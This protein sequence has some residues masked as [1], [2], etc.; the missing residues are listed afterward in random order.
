M[1]DTVFRGPTVSAGSLMDGRVEPFDG[2]VINYQGEVIPDVRFSPLPKNAMQPGQAESFLSSPYIVLVDNLLQSSANT[3]LIAASAAATSGVAVTLNATALGPG[4]GFA[5]TPSFCPGIPIIPFG[6]QSAT[7]VA[8]IDFGFTTG[9]TVA[10]SSTV[11]VV[12][13][14]LVQTGQWLMLGGT[15]ASNKSGTFAQIQTIAN[16]TT[17]TVLP[18]PVAALTNAPIGSVNLYGA[19]LL[20]PATQFGPSTPT[21]TGVNPYVA[22]GMASIF[23]P[24]EAVTR[25]IRFASTTGVLGT[26]QFLI[27]GY[28]VFGQ[29][30]TELVTAL[31][32][33]PAFSKKAFKYVQTI[34]PQQTQAGPFTISIGDTVGFHV[35]S[36][37]WEY[38]DTF[39]NG[40][41]ASNNAGWT[42]AFTGPATATTGD[43]RGTIQLSTTG[44]LGT[45]VGGAAT[46][47]STT[48][49]T[50]MMSVPLNNLVNATPINAVPMF[51]QTQA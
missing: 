39:W 26:A 28:D 10:A 38:T 37:K 17:I 27:V 51:G 19:G 7:T 35:R 50:L 31:G 8:A 15:G 43:V 46:A 29:R 48:R 14:S 25:N 20:P 47:N 22:A 12:D 42:A 33:V 9:T 21:P 45:S 41:F 3:A 4:G 24:A 2:P 34:T 23:N 13:S 5:G 6:Q 49:L 44:P 32:T 36:D 30:M 16:A 18:A 11:V 1:A 40:V